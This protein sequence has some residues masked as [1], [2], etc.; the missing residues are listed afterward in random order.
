MR[1][2]Y[3]IIFLAVLVGVGR[4]FITP[5]I[6]LDWT[7]AYIAHAHLFAGALLGIGLYDWKQR[8]GPSRF[9]FWLAWGLALYELAW[10]LAQKHLAGA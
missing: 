1:Q 2:K 4:V 8:L 7:D 10:Y 5:I 3:W 6:K 9:Y